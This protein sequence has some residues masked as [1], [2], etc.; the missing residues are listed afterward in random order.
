MKLECVKMNLFDVSDEYAL[1]HCISADFALGAGIAKEFA[2]RG[3]KRALRANYEQLWGDYGYCLKTTVNDKDYYNLVTKE[4][5]YDK[6]TY[7][8]LH[9]ALINLKQKVGNSA[10]LAMPKIGCGLDRLDW[11]I[12]IRYVEDVFD[13]TDVT[14]KVCFLWFKFLIKFKPFYKRYYKRRYTMSDDK[15]TINVRITEYLSKV[16]PVEVDK[17]MEHSVAFRQ[18]LESVKEDYYAEKII[19]TADDCTSVSFGVAESA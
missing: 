18:A 3:V 6:P 5:Y 9:E 7:R 8:T 11:N 2:K 4:H 10:Y 17:N 12:V 15:V 14:I 16:I 19:L 1:V 13:S